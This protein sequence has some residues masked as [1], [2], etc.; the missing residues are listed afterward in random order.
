MQNFMLHFRSGEDRRG[1]AANVHSEDLCTHGGFYGP[2]H[3]C[4]IAS[5]LLN[6]KAELLLADAA[7]FQHNLAK[8]NAD[9]VPQ[10][11]PLLGCAREDVT[12]V[13]SR[14][15]MLSTG[16]SPKSWARSRH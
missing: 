9:E 5:H 11:Q 12:W 8:R 15:G 13:L 1:G 7:S 3:A 4:I 6:D 14:H 10:A 2:P 16:T